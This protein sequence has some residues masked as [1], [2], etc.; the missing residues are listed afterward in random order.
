MGMSSEGLDIGIAPIPLGKPIGEPPI[1]VMDITVPARSINSV[2]Q[3]AAWTATA[4]IPEMRLQASQTT[5][6]LTLAWGVYECVAPIIKTDVGV[7]A[8]PIRVIDSRLARDNT[9]IHLCHCVHHFILDCLPDYCQIGFLSERLFKFYFT[10][11]GV[12]CILSSQMRYS[13]GLA[14]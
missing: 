14:F 11:V 8:A 10:T 5:R 3:G 12:C 2:V 13:D 6:G 7:T 4:T 1:S 9:H